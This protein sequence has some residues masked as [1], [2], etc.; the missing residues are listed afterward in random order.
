MYFQ[1]VLYVISSE[2]NGEE[3]LEEDEDDGCHAIVIVVIPILQKSIQI[4]QVYHDQ[5]HQG[6]HY[7][8]NKCDLFTFFEVVIRQ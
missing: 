1:V 2:A 6:C 7:V 4:H 5:G 3:D 8:D